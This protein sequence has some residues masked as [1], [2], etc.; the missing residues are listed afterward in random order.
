MNDNP[1]K[2]EGAVFIC[3]APAELGAVTKLEVKRG[4]VIARTES[5]RTMI[6]P[7]GG[8]HDAP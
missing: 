4:K 3:E 6:V 8:K 5:G 1:K 7:V 2:I